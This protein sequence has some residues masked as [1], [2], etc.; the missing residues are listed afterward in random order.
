MA[1]I[2]YL[3]G[4]IIPQSEAKLSPFNHGFLYSYGL[5][6]TMRVYNGAIFRLERHLIRLRKAAYTLRIESELGLFNLSTACYD[7]LEVNRLTDARL[8][9]T[10]TLGEGDITPNPATSNDITVFIAAKNLTPLSQENY[11]QGFQAIISAIRRNSRSPLSQLKTTGYLENILA[12]HE[13]KIIGADEA[14]LLNEKGLVAEGSSSNIFIVS[15]G[16]LF[17]PSLENGVLPGITR[18]TVLELAQ[19]LGIKTAER[20]IKLEMLMEA[21]EVFFTNSIIEIMPVTM[22][23]YKPIGGGEPGIITK[24][25][26]SAYND[27]V[28]N[29]QIKRT[30]LWK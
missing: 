27:L 17:T 25:L 13:A 9:L 20:N 3:N 7:I 19:S 8:R 6:E 16:K 14:V 11:H 23:D 26:I 22:I 29:Y 21:D 18:E 1:D 4:N 10:V 15:N 2:V 12:K 28:I 30:N 5:F 24:K